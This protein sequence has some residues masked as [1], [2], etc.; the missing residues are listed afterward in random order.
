MWPLLIE[1]IGKQES[2]KNLRQGHHMLPWQ[3]HFRR[4]VYSNF[5][6]FNIFFHLLAKYLEQGLIIK[7]KVN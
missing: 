5:D 7:L 1:F 4:H 2:G 6:F 3:P